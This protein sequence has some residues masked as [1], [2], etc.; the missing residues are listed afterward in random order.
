MYWV[1]TVDIYKELF[2]ERAYFDFASFE[3]ASLF[4]VASNSKVIGKFTDEANGKAST[5]FVHCDR[6]CSRS[7]STTRD[8]TEKHRAKMIMRGAS[9]EIR[10]QQY[11]DK[12][13]RPPENVL[14][15]HRIGSSLPQ[16]YKIEVVENSWT[17]F[18]KH[19][20]LFS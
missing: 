9:R 3:K 11:V 7:T 19:H 4:F 5:Y 1:E 2:A 13:Q 14:P 20:S 8:T 16:I 15:N 17:T 6:R 18:E 12:L 10:Q